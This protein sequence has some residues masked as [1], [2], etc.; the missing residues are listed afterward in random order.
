MTYVQLGSCEQQ[1]EYTCTQLAS[2]GVRHTPGF[3]VGSM[4]TSMSAVCDYFLRFCEENQCIIYRIIC[5]AQFDFVPYA[6]F[7]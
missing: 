3:V 4:K 7:R 5:V 6:T 2:C 1:N